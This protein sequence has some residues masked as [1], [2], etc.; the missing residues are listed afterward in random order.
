[1]MGPVMK[2]PVIKGLLETEVMTVGNNDYIESREKVFF[3]SWEVDEVP[4][5]LNPA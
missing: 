4:G 5:C 3:C 1:M 2:G